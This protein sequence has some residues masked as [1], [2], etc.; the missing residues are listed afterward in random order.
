MRPTTSMAR[1]CAS[2]AGC[3]PSPTR[4]RPCST[5]TSLAGRRAHRRS[6]LLLSAAT[7]FN[8]FDRSPGRDG[9]DPGPIAAGRLAAAVGQALRRTSCSDHVADHQRLFRRVALDLGP[10]PD[11]ARG[12][13]HR[14][15][16][17]EVRGRRPGAGGAPLP[18]RPLSPDRQLPAG[19]PAPQSPG[20]LE[21]RGPRP[22]EQQLDDQHQ[23][24]DEHVAG[25]GDEPRRVP[26]AALRPDPGPLRERTQDG[27]GQLRLRRLGLAPQC[28]RLVPVCARWATSARA[29][30]PG[31]S[32]R[33]P[34]PGSASTSGSTTSS[35]AT[36]RSSGTRPTP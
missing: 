20:D 4:G 26:R 11:E 14:P 22:L 1:G 13:A 5:T 33:C 31:P 2:S 10:S 27:P 29:I 16:G 35:A 24:R 18:V 3:G 32:G 7:S 8:G 19:Q 21:R 17:A 15:A 30:P 6:T 34:A 36:R 9:K 23:Y 25:R 12:A 28:R